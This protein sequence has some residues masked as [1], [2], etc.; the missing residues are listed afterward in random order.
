MNWYKVTARE[1]HVGGKKGMQV[2]YLWAQNVLDVVDRYKGLGGVPRD[3]LPEIRPLN[4][5]EVS[6]LEKAIIEDR[7][8]NVELA[9]KKA[10]RY[11]GR[12]NSLPPV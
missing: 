12:G 6:L 3:K 10:V 9:K 7:K 8:W 2:I 11:D 5:N 4:I 1:T